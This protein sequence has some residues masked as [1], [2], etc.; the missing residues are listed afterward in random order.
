[1]PKFRVFAI[2]YATKEIA[3]IEAETKEE[4]IKKGWEHENCEPGSLCWQCSDEYELN[5]IDEVRA[6][7]ITEE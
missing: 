6:E 5:E 4:A 2:L 3:T 7:E 1:M